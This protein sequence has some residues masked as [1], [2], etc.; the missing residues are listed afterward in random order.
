MLKNYD[1]IFWDFDGVIKDSI[2][3]KEKAFQNLF[4]SA[5]EDLKKKISLH[6][7]KNSGI[8]RYEKIPLYMDWA[9]E[10]LTEDNLQTFYVRFE[11]SLVKSVCNSKWVPGVENYLR[12]NYESKNFFLITGT[13][14]HEISIILEN[15]HIKNFFKEIYGSPIKKGKAIK[16][17]IKKWE[18]DKKKCIMIG[19]AI[20][21]LKA[22]VFNEISF[23]LRE[24]KF[25]KKLFKNY[26]GKRLKNFKN[27]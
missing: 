23:I 19:D 1:Y 11:K 13:P 12:K 22:S 3:I 2:K 8:S 20:E 18:L 6:H 21:D 14:D 25:N 10:D 15:L 27:L 7:I 24:H 5:D 26:D 4:Q 17:V 16:K 9:K